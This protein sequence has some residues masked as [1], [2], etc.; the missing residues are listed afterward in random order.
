[1][2]G[3]TENNW[4]GKNVRG[5]MLGIIRWPQSRKYV[6]RNITNLFRPYGAYKTCEMTMVSADLVNIIWIICEV[7]YKLETARSEAFRGKSFDRWGRDI[8]KIWTD[9]WKQADPKR[10]ESNLIDN[11]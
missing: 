4:W 7:G 1:M 8:K 9:E 6:A 5:A 2:H 10:D 11:I 3:L